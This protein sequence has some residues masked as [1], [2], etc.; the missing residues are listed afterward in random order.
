MAVSGL[1]ASAVAGIKCDE[2]QA[3]P[4]PF[5]VRVLYTN[6][7]MREGDMPANEE[8]DLRA[9]SMNPNNAAYWRERGYAKRPRNWDLLIAKSKGLDVKTSRRKSKRRRILLQ[10]DEWGLLPEDGFGRLSADDY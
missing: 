1:G 8:R 7:H 6:P 9:N 10:W 5:L 3:C 4:A 2:R